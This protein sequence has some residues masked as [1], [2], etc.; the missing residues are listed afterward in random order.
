M[1]IIRMFDGNVWLVV[2]VSVQPKEFR[3][4]QVLPH[5]TEQQH[6]ICIRFHSQSGAVLEKE[7]EKDK[8]EA[9]TF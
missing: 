5:Q 6:L 7:K 4:N 1:N 9:K 8:T 2:G 3:T